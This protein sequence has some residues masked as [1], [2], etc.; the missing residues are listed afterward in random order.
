MKKTL[1][2]FTYLME[3]GKARKRNKDEKL[4]FVYSS[5]FKL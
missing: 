2:R 5:S 4:F 3:E 1:I